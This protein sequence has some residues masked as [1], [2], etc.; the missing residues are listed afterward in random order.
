MGGARGQPASLAGGRRAMSH[1][2]RSWPDVAKRIRGAA[3]VA[4][5]LDFD[6]TLAPFVAEPSA[7]RLP[8]PTRQILQRLARLPG[9][10][11]WIISARREA[12][13][14]ARIAVPYLR[15]LGLYGWENGAAPK[16][17]ESQNRMLAEAR[18][19]VAETT[20][21]IA[22]VRIEDKQATFALHWRGAPPE[23]LHEAGRLFDRVM[24]QFDGNLR[25]IRGDHVWEVTPAGL[26]GK[27]VAARRYW[28]AWT[29]RALPIYLGDNLADEPAFAALADGITVCVGPARS[30]RARFR[31]RD[32]LEVREFLERLEEELRRVCGQG[33]KPL[34]RL[35]K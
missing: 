9:L 30:T 6:G 18:R 31:L 1:L 33:R 15:Y 21:G 14:R 4:L 26:L 32:P 24:A 11:V 8:W 29:G 35:P 2:L 28:R 16:F 3:S 34:P 12:D 7:A 25:V 20:G 17:E 22:G 27:G 23:S 5:F 19:G 10:R 13:L